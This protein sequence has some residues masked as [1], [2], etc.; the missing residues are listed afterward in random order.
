MNEGL[1][2]MFTLSDG[3]KLIQAAENKDKYTPETLAD[4]ATLI[5]ARA[6]NDK[7]TPEQVKMRDAIYG[8]YL[9]TDDSAKQK[10]EWLKT[11]SSQ[12]SLDN[13]QGIDSITGLPGGKL[14]G[15]PTFSEESPYAIKGLKAAEGGKWNNKDGKWDYTPSQYQ[16]ERDSNYAD[17]LW[18][19][20]QHEK[21]NGIDRII[22][23][24]GKILE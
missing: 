9:H 15:H 6:K 22:L 24:N 16:F 12:H 11:G 20:F 14:P 13:P 5:K 18:N 19:Y 1:A 8:N 3:V 23:P 21:G 4:V 17:G 10:A 7:Y 2:G